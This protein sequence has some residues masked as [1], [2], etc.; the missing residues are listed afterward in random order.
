MDLGGTPQR[1]L[2][3]HA[4]DELAHLFADPGS[5]PGRTRLPAP[6]GAKAHSMP[7]HNR[8]GPD[9]GYGVKNARTGTI[10]PNEQTQM[11]PDEALAGVASENSIRRSGG[12]TRIRTCLRLMIAIGVASE[13]PIRRSGSW[14]VHSW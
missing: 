8:L 6:V 3:T 10:E 1:V 2:K 12:G 11:R 13:N 5:G 14:M 9:D 4:S 7:T